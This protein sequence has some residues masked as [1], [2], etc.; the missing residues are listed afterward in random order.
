MAPY[1]ARDFNHINGTQVGKAMY[2]PDLAMLFTCMVRVGIM[3]MYFYLD[4]RPYLKFI[5]HKKLVTLLALWSGILPPFSIL[6]LVA[7]GRQKRWY[8]H[9]AS[10][11]GVDYIRV[12]QTIK[13]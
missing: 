4:G 9:L 12:Y 8:F 1:I 3:I 10:E 6:P 11:M 5:N 2:V 13:Q 7:L